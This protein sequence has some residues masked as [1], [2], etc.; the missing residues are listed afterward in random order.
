[1]QQGMLKQTHVEPN[2]LALL[3]LD[4]SVATAR[5]LPL[6]GAVL[7]AAGALLFGHRMATTTRSDEPTRIQFKYGPLL[8][9]ISRSNTAPDTRLVE[10]ATIDDLAKLA[11]R[12]D[13]VM[14]YEQRGPIYH[15][16]VQEAGVTYHYQ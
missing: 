9:G 6:L 1:V 14:L 11:E 10:I 5:W 7:A 13:R 2:T 12:D 15:Y 8:I 16:F 4:L 3:G